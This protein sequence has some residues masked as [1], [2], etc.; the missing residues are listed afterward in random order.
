MNSDAIVPIL[1]AAKRNHSIGTSVYYKGSK[2]VP[3]YVCNMAFHP[4][5]FAYVT[6]PLSQGNNSYVISQDG[7]SLRVTKGYDQD[8]KCSAYSIDV[9]YGLKTVQ[10]DLALR[11]LG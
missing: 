10:A 11:V 1:G 9:L 3:I 4:M 8:Q 6:R 5:A 2:D 7:F